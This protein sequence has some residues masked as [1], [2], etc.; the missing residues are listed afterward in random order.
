MDKNNKQNFKI[1]FKKYAK[2]VV[3]M[4][5]KREKDLVKRE[6]SK[7]TCDPA[8]P[9]PLYQKVLTRKKARKLDCHPCFA[10]F[11]GSK[12]SIITRIISE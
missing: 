10:D 11:S 8:P 9:L 7:R 2:D 1:N 6:S 4:N 12:F 5:T 3:Q